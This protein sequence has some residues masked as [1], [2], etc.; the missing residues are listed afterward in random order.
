[1]LRTRGRTAARAAVVVLA[2]GAVSGSASVA[3]GASLSRTVRISEQPRLASGARVIGAVAAS[4][5][6]HVTIALKPRDSS[7]LAAYAREVST[8]GSS[9]YR[10]YLT[11]EQ[12]A[13]RFGASASELA[14]VTASLR[15]HGLPPGSISA[16]HLSVRIAGTAAQVEHAFSFTFRRMALA[17]GRRAVVASAAP[18][19]DRKIAGYVQAVIG[20]SSLGAPRPLSVRPAVLRPAAKGRLAARTEPRVATGGP[21]PCQAA[22]S[23]AASQGAFTADQIAS[24]YRF[25]GLF[26]AGAEGQG[27]TIAIYELE[28]ND[29]ADIAAY[30][31]CYGTN[32]SVSYVQVDGG[33]G[34]GPGVGEAALDIEQVIGLAPK[35]NLV[36]YQAPNANV[37]SPGSGPY[38]LYTQIVTDDRA[39][40]VSVSW[41]SCE[42]QEGAGNAHAE[43]TLFEEAAAQGQS[44]VV[45]AGD[46]GSEDC[47]GTGGIPNPQLAV[48]DPASQ[49][50][51]TAV[52]GTTLN[53]LGPAPSEIVWNNGGNASGL[54][55]VQGGASGGGVS[56][57]WAMPSYQSGAAT[58][59]HVIQAN[60]S[61]SSCGFAGPYCREVPDVSA[62]ADP[63]TGYI[64]Y[65]NGSQTAGALQPSGWQ[66]IGGTSAAAPL[67]AALLAD[68]DSSPACRGSAIGFADPA[69]YRAAGTAYN[70][71]FNDVTSGE[72]DFT[73]TNGGLYRAGPGYDMATG[74][75]TPNAGAL[76]AALC[77]DAL[78]IDNPGTQTSTAGQQV[79]FQ[80]RTNAP[81][82]RNLSFSASGLPSGLSINRSTGRI[83]G[84][85]KGIGTSSV[86]LFATDRGLAFRPAFLT[87]K[88]IGP[89][90][91]S[92]DSL[93]GVGSGQPTL[94]LT[95]TAGS[96]A[97]ELSS[98][99]IGLPKGLSFVSLAGKVTVTGK[100]GR[101]V[102][103]GSRILRGRLQI[104]LARPAQ[105]LRIVI[106]GGA[107]RA[108]DGLLANVRRHR[109]AVLTLTVTTTDAGRHSV[110]MGAR[111]RPRS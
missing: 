105:K 111:L 72:N 42:Q 74:L 11:P 54:L 47:N 110:A 6:V 107:I 52:G 106:G 51:A 22:S 85:A 75:G 104:T 20:L 37:D 48:D 103:F 56:Q 2:A 30:Q 80:V 63:S 5:P 46:N 19:L 92:Q 4:T 35:A 78:Q 12:F 27:K 60:S 99:S 93:S 24:A 31:A 32:A 96:K 18:A 82:A 43:A 26:G 58:A 108:T 88:V 23:A 17:S 36:V 15:S 83:A 79:S 13:Q 34:S 21:Q 25:S 68:V 50:F 38:D 7:A 59:L 97:P 100:N 66:A 55:A 49:P 89:P 70:A 29:P 3:T 45:V 65:W 28:P 71:Y 95:L 53:S 9:V 57:I 69:L 33:A 81:S 16:N 62:D 41:G 109:G 10:D 39:Q 61:G 86:E 84:R 76:G 40:V 1:M 91:V 73:N 44:M 8:P 94:A 14:A 101:R 67:W 98:A 87:W 64:I 90:T 77:A 102:A